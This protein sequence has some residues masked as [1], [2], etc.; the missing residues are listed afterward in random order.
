MSSIPPFAVNGRFLTQPVTGV[1]RYA[2]NVVTA[3]NAV[4]SDLGANAPIIAPPSAADPGLS[5]MSCISAGPLVG[6]AWEQ[7]V[8]PSQWR[9]RLLNLCNT[10]PVLKAD[11]VV[12]IH[13]ANVF[14][15][16]E[17]YGP[18]FRAVYPPLH[19]LLARR[20][21]R[22]ATV[23]A[24]SAR[25]IARFLPVGAADIVVLPNGHE[26]ALTWDPAL[27]RTGPEGVAGVW[28]PSDRSF[29]LALGSRARH[30]NM[31]LLLAAAPEFAA[32]GLDLIVAG[33][34]AGIFAAE[35]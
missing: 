2:R 26:H 31:Q 6:H 29:V 1:Q 25:Q 32:M 7:I 10:A 20:S 30:K 23:S 35:D 12:C 27:A 13:D 19:R 5:M 18:T 4:L 34:G 8:L 11:Q 33:G 14:I 22:I 3:M 24:Y 21:A 28:E 17:S 16:P 9:G 15:A